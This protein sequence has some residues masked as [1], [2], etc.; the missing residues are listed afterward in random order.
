M[1]H[2][3]HEKSPVSNYSQ[4]YSLVARCTGLK[5]AEWMRAA[6]VNNS[7]SQQNNSERAIVPVNN[8][9][10]KYVLRHNVWSYLDDEQPCQG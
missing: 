9:N 1:T 3:Y 7:L 2:K 8:Q 5:P 10:S 6:S 4:R